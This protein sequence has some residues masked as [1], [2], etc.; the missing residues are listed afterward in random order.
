[1]A[2]PPVA[3]RSSG[4][5]PR[6]RRCSPAAP[7]PGAIRRKIA[8][9]GRRSL[10]VAAATGAPRGPRTSCGSRPIPVLD[11]EA[12]RLHGTATSTLRMMRSGV[13]SLR[14]DAEGLEIREI[15]DGDG[16]VLKHR[17]LA[18]SIEVLL[19]E[20]VAVGDELAVTVRYAATGPDALH[21][22]LEDGEEFRPEAY[23][24]I[25]RSP[26]AL[27]SHQ[28]SAGRAHHGRARACRARRGVRGEQRRA[29]RE[30]RRRSGSVRAGGALQ[31]L[32][33]IPV[34]AI[35][36]AAGRFESD[37]ATADR[38]A[39]HVHL[40]QGTDPSIARR[41]AEES[42]QAVRHLVYRLQR[43]YPAPR[44]RRHAERGSGALRGRDDVHH[45]RG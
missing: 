25:L 33:P 6:W 21:V 36:I 43:R 5:H 42:V 12:P 31:Q 37:A 7:V 22:S 41:T 28:R 44:P 18:D 26:R 11:P 1:M 4:S 17:V 14:F 20:P 16:R 15:V 27:A 23:V 40:P 9:R 38:V 13:R 29:V 30:E 19:D 32:E 2:R 3:G 24:R 35:V 39:L 8:S 34:E 10:S 45:R